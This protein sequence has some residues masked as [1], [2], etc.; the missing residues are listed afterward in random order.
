MVERLD[1][2]LKDEKFIWLFFYV[3][4]ISICGGL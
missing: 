2:F 4:G 3:M 1:G